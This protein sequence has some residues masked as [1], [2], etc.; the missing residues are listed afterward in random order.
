MILDPVA[1][2]LATAAIDDEPLTEEE[3]QA[4]NA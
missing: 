1:R 4:L 2:F 3:E